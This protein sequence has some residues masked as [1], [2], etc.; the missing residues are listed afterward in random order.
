MSSATLG[1]VKPGLVKVVRRLAV[2]ACALLVALA[3]ASFVL[4][5]RLSEPS[6]YAIGPSPRWLAAPSVSFPSE[7]GSTIRGWLA[8][9]V[10][11]RGV[12]LLLPGLRG[13]RTSMLGRARM[14]R[15]AGIGSLLIDFQ[16]TGESPGA[17]IT[18]GWLERHDVAAAVA[19]LRRELPGERIGIVGCSLGGAATL[20]ATPPLRVDAIVLEGVYP[21]IDEAVANRLR[22]R[23]GPLGG[24]LVPCLTLQLPLRLG[25]STRELRPIDHVGSVGC[26]VLVAAG[27]LDDRTTQRETE[28]LFAA[29]SE[30]KELWLVPGAGH[31]DLLRYA[32]GEYQSRVLEFLGT[33]LQQQ[34]GP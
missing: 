17:A 11:G 16:G 32:G 27:T 3:G 14:L 30:P 21:A 15:D 7:S 26:P 29:A 1:G 6:L 9:G 12:V 19:F 2:G 33:A 4:A 13:D 18:F 25:V 10:P 24:L 5:S 23:F 31:Q 20:L 28:A 22:V 34:C 8:R